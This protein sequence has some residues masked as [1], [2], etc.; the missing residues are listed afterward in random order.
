MVSYWGDKMKDVR[1]DLD[2]AAADRLRSHYAYY[3]KDGMSILEFGA[4]EESYLPAELKVGQH[5]G[6]SLSKDLMDKNP[7]LTEKFVVDIDQVVKEQGIDSEQIQTLED[8]AASEDGLFDVVLMANTMEFLTN[9][10]EVF[11]SA[12]RL[13]K[14]G[15]KMF[16]AFTA[17]DSPYT[18]KFS[19][20]QTNQWRNFNDDQHMYVAGSFFQ[21]SASEGW[22]KLKGF[23][24]SPEGAKNINNSNPLSKLSQAS[25]PQPMFVVQATKASVAK[26]IDKEDPEE[27]FKSLMWMMPTLEDRDKQLVAPRLARTFLHY[28]YDNDYLSN[29][30]QYLPKVYEILIR[31]DQFAFPF[32]LQA[33]LAA[34]LIADK[35][36]NANAD[37]LAA[38][39]MGLG[40]R[41]PSK[42]FWA[43]IG[44]YTAAMDPEAKVNLLA[45]L[46]PKFGSN[47]PQQEQSLHNFVTGLKPTF[48]YIKNKCPTL[49]ETD[50]QLLG[51]ELLSS[52]IL[53]PNTTTK[54]QFALWLQELNEDELLN[55][56]NNRKQIKKDA[57]SDMN[58]MKEQRQA[59]IQERENRKK[60]MEEQV[61]NARNERTMVFNEQTGKMEEAKK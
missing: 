20:A 43:P 15:G 30:L 35:Q 4:A 1:T 44:Q 9:P 51:T 31:M 46:V 11:K 41:K 8:E 47:D 34:D 32:N 57:V 16:V 19:E 37:Q 39:K 38:L 60:A 6:V 55:Y 7:S 13:C 59:L 45:H 40:L 33:Q 21:F 3:I 56:L 50:I 12:W 28:N 58:Q 25:R 54:T 49:S 14:P 2:E 42:S 5:V 18:N 53:I 48:A 24:I 26:S 23:D 29:Q 17:K 27:S 61:E 52:E 10:R 36:F 22:S